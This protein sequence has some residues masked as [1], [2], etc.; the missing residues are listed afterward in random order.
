M[1]LDPKDAKSGG[2]DVAGQL[3]LDRR[4][5]L[6]RGRFLALVT[7]AYNVLEGVVAILFGIRSDSVALTGFGVDSFVE[8]TSAVVV[9]ASP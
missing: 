6:K 5:W 1:T 8:V 3:T 7:V 9:C 4:A 2:E